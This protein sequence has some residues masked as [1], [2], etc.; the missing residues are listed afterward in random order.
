MKPVKKSIIIIIIFF[1]LIL[2]AAIPQQVK[3]DTTTSNLILMKETVSKQNIIDLNDEDIENINNL[4]KANIKKIT[5][6]IAGDFTI[7]TDID[8]GYT[9][10]FIHEVERQDR[11]YLYFVQNFKTYFEKDNLTLVNLETTLT[12]ATDKA[13]KKF[14]FK[15]EPDFVNILKLADIEAVN[16]ANNHTH[17]YLEKGYDETIQTLEEAEVGYFGNDF[18]YITKIEGIS[19]G[20]LGYE[21]WEFN[22]EL[23]TKLTED[24]EYMNQFTDLTVISFHWGNENQ[25]YPNKTQVDIAHYAIDN[26]ADLVFGHHPH[27]IQGI[28]EYEGKYI[29]Y[30][31]GN[32]LYGGHRNPADKDT[33]IFQQT[34]YFDK[35]NVL[36]PD[37]ETTIIP[38]SIS[39]VS[40]R[41]DYQPTPL[42][43]KEKERFENKMN[44]LSAIF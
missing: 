23:Q 15:G 43:S 41:N 6:S 34:F 2:F 37:T 5:I 30:S 10:S 29:V 19:I 8:Y 22:T 16:I 42:D 28:E 39:S 36:L 24:L 27:V 7:G 26:G 12:T 3:S 35:N 1:G 40:W 20:V 38:F 25:V 44:K 14:T 11:N 31:L 13:I 9:D 18:R 21:G 4:K 32:F 33:F 17:D